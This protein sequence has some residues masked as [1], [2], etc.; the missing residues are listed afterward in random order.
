[1][2][3]CYNTGYHSATKRTPFQIVY[4]RPPPS[5][6]PYVPGTTKSAAVEDTLRVRD[7]ISQEV[8]Q[9]L[10]DAQ[11]RMKQVYDKGHVEQSFSEGEWVY[12]KLQGYRQQSI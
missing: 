10:L 11:N 5:M 4:G 7:E 3:Y 1:V 6:L 2:E 12:L 8:R 9:H